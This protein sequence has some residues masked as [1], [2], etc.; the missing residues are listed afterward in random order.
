VS[1]IHWIARGTETPKDR[2]EVVHYE[3]IESV[4]WSQLHDFFRV[5]ETGGGII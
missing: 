1:H 4:I 2:G 5:A 3:S